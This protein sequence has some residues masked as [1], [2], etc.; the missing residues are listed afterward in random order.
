MCRTRPSAYSSL[1]R[2]QAGSPGCGVRGAGTVP[3]SAGSAG[4]AGRRLPRRL[5]GSG[6]G[7]S[8]GTRPTHAP[9]RAAL[10]GAASA[11][12]WGHAWPPPPPA[13]SAR[14]AA[15]RAR[16]GCSDRL[17]SR[18]R[19][20]RGRGT[21]AEG[22]A[23]R[24]PNSEARE[25]APGGDPGCPGSERPSP[26]CCSCSQSN[27]FPTGGQAHVL[28]PPPPHATRGPDSCAVTPGAHSE[29]LGCV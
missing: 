21:H 20:G 3:G 16:T 8:G 12:S 2:G 18:G 10:A 15:G 28:K 5:G 1:A 11:S 17:P 24:A 9:T 27:P 22:W 23:S 19:Q 4:S 13:E 25:Q 7:G 26:N 14:W 6:S 29:G